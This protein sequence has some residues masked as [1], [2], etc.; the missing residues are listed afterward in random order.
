MTEQ[1]QRE[2]VRRLW[3]H[4]QKTVQ[5]GE[6]DLGNSFSIAP[7]TNFMPIISPEAPPELP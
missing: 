7:E 2:F 1:E 4:G 3:Q 6:I 5:I